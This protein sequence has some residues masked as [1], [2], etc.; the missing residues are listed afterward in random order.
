MPV[1]LMVNNYIKSSLI[2]CFADDT[3]TMKGITFHLEKPNSQFDPEIDLDLDG[4]P[5]AINF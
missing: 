1:N 5:K 4:E 2:H 3:F